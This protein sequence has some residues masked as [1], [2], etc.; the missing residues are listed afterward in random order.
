MVTKYVLSSRTSSMVTGG[1][2]G[3]L[4]G[5]TAFSVGIGEIDMSM[6]PETHPET[7]RWDHRHR[8]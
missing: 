7:Q 4:G 2:F 3:F 1:L 5:E 6:N 8:S